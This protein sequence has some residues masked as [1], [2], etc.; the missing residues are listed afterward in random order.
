LRRLNP[1]RSYKNGHAKI[2]QLLEP[3][4]REPEAQVKAPRVLIADDSPVVLRMIETML[5]AAGLE[6]VTAHDGLEA[7]EKAI[8]E[9]VSLVILDVMMPR[10]NGYQ[11]CRL[12]KN[13]PST[14]GLPVVI[15]TSKDQA[16]DRFWG[17]E[18][19]ADYYITKDSE[20]QRIL[21]LVRTVL[22]NGDGR[23]KTRTTASARSSDVDILTRVN[24][25][26]DRKLYEATI[27]TEIG[28]VARSLR[29]FDDTFT[30][31]M[32]LIARVV[33]FTVG[34]MAFIDTDD[35][36]VVILVNHP[37]EPA[38]VEDHKARLSEALMRERKNVV[39]ARTQA[40][41]L[42]PSTVDESSALETTLGGFAAFPLTTSNRLSG[43]LALGGRTLARLSPETEAFLG[44]VANQA[45]IVVENS[46]MFER[47]RNLSIRDSLTELYNHRH[48]MTLVANEYER[49]GR[50]EDAMSVLMIDI[51]HF[52]NFN[53]EHGHQAGDAVLREVARLLRE[54]LRQVDAIGRYG[55]EEF[56]AILPHTNFDD[57]HLTG[58]RVRRAVEEQVFRYGD[59]RLKVTVSVGVA[60]YPS[61]P[62][63]SPGA[64]IREADRALYRAKEAGRN[65]VV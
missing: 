3:D 49:V 22:G 30:S 7:I 45:Q 39:F 27:L 9:D 24:D 23:R 19:G 33:D 37:A 63:D 52:K 55:G 60:T 34:A 18:T 20:P 56:M 48:S 1:A 8:A 65:R 10:M 41:S 21:E 58:E 36:E 13:E 11:A 25:L 35:L 5:A 31:V 14:K 26:L 57:A 43:L 54:A 28:R 17:L 62:V 50:Y 51:D 38:V 59:K 64:L 44:Q 6:V 40:K 53:D 29:S 4:D 32:G 15:L 61:T 12:L 42:S 46:R 47:I 16:G 2:R